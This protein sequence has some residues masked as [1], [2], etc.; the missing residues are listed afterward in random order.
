M[1]SVPHSTNAMVSGYLPPLLSFSRSI[2]L[3]TTTRALLIA[4]TV[5]MD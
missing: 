2:S 5:G 1:L 4:A 3:S